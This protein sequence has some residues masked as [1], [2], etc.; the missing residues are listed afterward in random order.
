MKIKVRA[1]IAVLCALFL[2][3]HINAQNEEWK[4]DKTKDGK[5]LVSY[6]FLEKIDENGKKFNVLEFEAVTRA[7]VSME[8]CLA[9]LKDDSGTR[10][11]R[12]LRSD[13]LLMLS[14]SERKVARHKMTAGG[15]HP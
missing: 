6:N 1:G 8:S 14:S 3:P 7:A 9:V 5:V 12:Y 13:F 4:Q 10:G 15:R 2:S 11:D